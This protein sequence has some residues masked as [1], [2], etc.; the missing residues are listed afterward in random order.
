MDSTKV[1]ADEG[2]GYE[3]GLGNRQSGISGTGWKKKSSWRCNLVSHSWSRMTS[4]MMWE[5]SWPRVT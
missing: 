3:A 5:R 2:A 4:P 1:Q